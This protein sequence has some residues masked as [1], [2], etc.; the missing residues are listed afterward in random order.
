[1]IIDFKQIEL[2][3]DLLGTPKEEDIY[4]FFINFF[5]SFKFKFKKRVAKME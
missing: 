4:V 5:L 1:M 3:T 2:I